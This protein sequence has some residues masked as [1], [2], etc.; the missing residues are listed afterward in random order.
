[1]SVIKPA[2]Q[3]PDRINYFS[4]AN[5]YCWIY[6]RDGEKKLLA[7]PISYLER[8][9]PGFIRVH[10]T[11]LVNPA[12]IKNLHEPPRKKMGGQVS[13][14][15]GEVFPVS[16][17]RWAQVVELV[18]HHQGEFAGP[19]EP[20]DRMANPSVL[21]IKQPPRPILP[22]I[23]LIIDDARNALL[24]EQLIRKKWPAY[25]FQTVSQSDFLSDM[26]KQS[27]VSEHPTLILLD[28]R[29]ATLERLRT[30]TRLKADKYLR[31]IPV[32]LL[33]LPTDA[34]IITGYQQRANSVI[35]L[36]TDNRFFGQ[37]IERICQFWLRMAALPG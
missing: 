5:N 33:V 1:M 34:S 13:L 31:H 20:A 4:G 16:R 37:T 35:A 23:L 21:P 9:L 24:A 3:Y 28:A 29:T 15:S 22:S 2:L 25:Q 17:R 11:V 27:P 19:A 10:K 6:F 26:L 7:K 36:S 30:L 14:D 18:Q 32:V 8:Q 12:Y